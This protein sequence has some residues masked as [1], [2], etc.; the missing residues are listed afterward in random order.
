VVAGG[1]I[2]GGALSVNFAIIAGVS[3]Y[4]FG[5]V[6]DV[7]Y[8]GWLECPAEGLNPRHDGKEANPHIR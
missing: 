1:T 7:D 4:L 5:Q 2:S 3:R 8:G 6:A